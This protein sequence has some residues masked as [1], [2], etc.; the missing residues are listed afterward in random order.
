MWR[1]DSLEKTLILGKIEGR[2]RREQL[3][4]SWL[5]GTT[6]SMD[7][8]LSKLWETVKDREAWRAAVHGVAESDMTEWLNNNRLASCCIKGPSKMDLCF[9]L[10][11]QTSLRNL[12]AHTA[13]QSKSKCGY[14]HGFTWD[15][16]D[17]KR[18]L[19]L[20][21]HFLELFL[22]LSALS[23]GPVS[24]LSKVP[25]KFSQLFIASN[26]VACSSLKHPC[27]SLGMKDS[28]I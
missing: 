3:R 28:L 27:F 8:S 4:M 21:L 14:R 9:W 5:D 22:Q 11:A 12:G 15:S 7:M 6:D 19:F 23:S 2:R 18:P 20:S 17:V 13:E 16:N 24:C 10:K 1:A 26:E 25:G